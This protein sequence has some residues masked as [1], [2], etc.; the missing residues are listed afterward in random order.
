[1]FTCPCRR[2]LSASVLRSSAS[3][4]E[5]YLQRHGYSSRIATAY[6]HAV[7]HFA[8]WLTK[9]RLTPGCPDPDQAV[10]PSDSSCRGSHPET[11]KPIGHGDRRHTQGDKDAQDPVAI[12]DESSKN[13]HRS[14]PFAEFET[15]TVDSQARICGIDH[16]CRSPQPHHGHSGRRRS[17]TAMIKPFALQRGPCS[18]GS[19][20][21]SGSAR[22]ALTK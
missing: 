8:H 2:W 21:C 18:T 13:A 17:G 3:S 11:R 6:L 20:S 4:Y 10:P 9:T 12:F 7:G 19:L 1:M 14:A 5:A 16:G 22:S 15:P